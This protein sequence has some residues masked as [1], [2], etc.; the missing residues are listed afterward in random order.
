MEKNKSA[1]NKSALNHF[2]PL[3]ANWFAESIGMPTDLQIL[4][5]PQIA[6]G[7]HVLITAPTGSGKTMAAFLWAIN[8]LITG[9]W[10]LD[11]VS[12]LYI[13]PLKAL[14]NDIRGNLMR[15]LSELRTVFTRS[16]EHFPPLGIAIR[17]GDTP[18]S[19]RRRM[20]REPPEILITT[21]ESLNLLFTSLTICA[22]CFYSL[23]K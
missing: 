10:P 14:N 23:H 13:S 3:V 12:V 20:L 16:G 19:E 15:P 22:Q 17:S 9:K 5:W 2:H 11:R 6:G 7:E 1:Q 21:P 8:E 18:Q 4:A